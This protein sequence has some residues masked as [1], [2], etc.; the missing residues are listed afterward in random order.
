MKI[1]RQQRIW[2]FAIPVIV[3]ACMLV[4]AAAFADSLLPGDGATTD[5]LLNEGVVYTLAALGLAGPVRAGDVVICE[6]GV[7]CNAS[8][9]TSQWSDVLVFYNATNGAYIADTTLD[10]NTAQI[11]SGDDGSL[12]TF[13]SQYNGLSSNATFWSENPTGLTLV[14]TGGFYQVNSPETT[15]AVPEPSSLLLLGSGLFG[16]ATLKLRRKLAA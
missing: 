6:S 5:P 15:A 4:P 1:S 7:V 14:G 8:T 11:F 2:R 3:M 9:P 13:L 10:T 16:L 12:G